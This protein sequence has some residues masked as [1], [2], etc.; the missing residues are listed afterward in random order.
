MKSVDRRPNPKGKSLTRWRDLIDSLSEF[1]QL[2][3]PTVPSGLE[4]Q[5]ELV[6]SRERPLRRR[7]LR[8][9]TSSALTGFLLA[10][11]PAAHAGDPLAGASTAH[12][13]DEGRL[14]TSA[15]EKSVRAW[16]ESHGLE[17]I[18]AGSGLALVFVT[19]GLV[20]VT[21]R[22]VRVRHGRP[23]DAEDLKG[24]LDPHLQRIRQMNHERKANDWI[25]IENRNEVGKLLRDIYQASKFYSSD[26]FDGAFVPGDLEE[27]REFVGV[28]AAPLILLIRVTTERQLMLPP[29][30]VFWNGE[31]NGDMRRNAGRKICLALQ[32]D[33]E[34]GY[35]SDATRK[36][37]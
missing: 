16:I 27:L 34:E 25:A 5:I 30:S 3:A 35:Q 12:A 17:A 15:M 11:A 13:G 9:L 2:M 26:D 1:G 37:A 6:E 29:E 20:Y 28:T 31:R 22:L 33:L 24:R 18:T 21:G 32:I 8:I 14:G 23:K 4:E 10:G 19:G 7:I 36:A